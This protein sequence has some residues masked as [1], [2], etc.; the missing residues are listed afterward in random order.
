MAASLGD[1]LLERLINSDAK[2]PQDGDWRTLS[3]SKHRPQK[4][5]A[6]AR[7]ESVTED[8]P[9]GLRGELGRRRRLRDA[10]P[11]HDGL[12]RCAK[13]ADPVDL[14]I[15]G[16]HE[17][18]VA[19]LEEGDRKCPQEAARP[20]SNR[21]EH[22]RP[23]WQAGA[24][25]PP[26]ERVEEANCRRSAYEDDGENGDDD[27]FERVPHRGSSLSDYQYDTVSIAMIRYRFDE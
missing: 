11:R 22:V 27:G 8:G 10:A 6:P 2:E 7:R 20:T 26:H 5:G 1:V 25:E 18:A 12:A 24:E 14:A 19:E 15:G 23:R 17:A 16:L 9:G 4:A 3:T 21:E 13:V